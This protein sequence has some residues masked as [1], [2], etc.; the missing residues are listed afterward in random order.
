MKT[1]QKFFLLVSCI[2]ITS[3]SLNS[4]VNN[5]DLSIVIDLSHIE[6][7]SKHN[8]KVTPKSGGD[9]SLEI[10]I[11][12]VSQNEE[13]L[14]SYSVSKIA[15]LDLP[16]IQKENVAIINNKAKVLFNNISVGIKA[17]ITV[18]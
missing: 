17:I 3:C 12:N 18:T 5:T 8:L 15:S 16:I 4:Y 7:K 9:Q 10:T 13:P 11:Y 6:K 1:L 14:D 2:F